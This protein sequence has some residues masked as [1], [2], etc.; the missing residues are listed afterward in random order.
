VPCA[1]TRERAGQASCHPPMT[2]RTRFDAAPRY[3]HARSDAR[4][5][6]SVSCDAIPR[7]LPILLAPNERGTTGSL[8]RGGWILLPTGTSPVASERQRAVFGLVNDL[9]GGPC[10]PLPRQ[11]CSQRTPGSRRSEPWPRSPCRPQTGAISAW[12]SF[13]AARRGAMASD[14]LRRQGHLH[15][16]HHDGHNPRA[17]LFRWHDGDPSESRSSRYTLRALAVAT[18]LRSLIW[19]G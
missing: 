1:C 12:I 8:R 18:T 2:Q 10:R 4:D 9:G 14:Y 16:R 5:A 11:S 6:S 15:R 3:S 13:S 19:T 7:G 17:H